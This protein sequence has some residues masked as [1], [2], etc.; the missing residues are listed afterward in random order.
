MFQFAPESVR[1]AMTAPVKEAIAFNKRVA[2]FNLGQLKLA[3]E[4]INASVKAGR[5][6]LEASVKMAESNT[7]AVVD[8]MSPKASA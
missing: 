8:W 7:Q 3:E 4:V 6:S 2:E 5:A 1:E